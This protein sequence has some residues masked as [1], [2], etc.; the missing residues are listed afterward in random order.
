MHDFPVDLSNFHSHVRLHVLSLEL[1]QLFPDYPLQ[2]SLVTFI[3]WQLKWLLIQGLHLNPLHRFQA[4]FQPLEGQVVC[5]CYRCVPSGVEE[6]PQLPKNQDWNPG[7]GKNLHTD[8][9]D[10]LQQL[11]QLTRWSLSLNIAGCYDLN[12]ESDEGRR[13]Y[14]TKLYQGERF[15]GRGSWLQLSV[16][17]GWQRI[18]QS[19]N[20]D[21]SFSPSLAVTIAWFAQL[22]TFFLLNFFSPFF[23]PL[24]ATNG[25]SSYWTDPFSRSCSG[26]HATRQ[27]YKVVKQPLVFC[28]S[29][30]TIWGLPT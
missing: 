2:T 14:A 23:S 29:S 8:I 6:A 10:S 12:M 13:I 19:S 17:N 9:T 16:R 22:F 26:L 20:S 5:G 25:R 24:S 21:I 1:I 4:G 18:K 30:V 3:V 11:W 7:Q 28:K 15:R 27:N